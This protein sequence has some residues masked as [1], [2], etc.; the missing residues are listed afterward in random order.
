[1][2]GTTKLKFPMPHRR[3]KY[4][5]QDVQSISAPLTN[6][7]QKFLGTAEISIDA[8]SPTSPHEASRPWETHSTVSGVSGI[9]VAISE[10][11][12][13]GIGDNTETAEVRTRGRFAWDQESDIIP[14]GL[15]LSA[16]PTLE[17]TTDASSLRRRGSGST[18]VSYYDKTKLPLSISQQ[19]S[20][21]AM[22]KGL[23]NKAAE[24][25]DLESPR[26]APIP[27]SHPRRK[28]SKLD[29]TRLLSSSKLSKFVQ[30]KGGMMLGPDLLT[31]SPSILSSSPGF[32]SSDQEPKPEKKLRRV[33]TKE[34]LR[35]LQ[36]QRTEK[37]QDAWGAEHGSATLRKRATDTGNLHHLYEHYEETSI[38]ERGNSDT[39]A[40]ASPRQPS[41]HASERDTT[42]VRRNASLSGPSSP[43]VD[44]PRHQASPSFSA[45]TW[46]PFP[47]YTPSEGCSPIAENPRASVTSSNLASPACDYATSVSS[48]HTRTSRASKRTESFADFDP[49]ATSVLSLS[50]DSEDDDDQEPP[51]TA[52]SIPSVGSRDSTFSPTDY[53]RPSNTSSLQESVRSHNKSR[54]RTSLSPKPPFSSIPEHVGPSPPKINPRSSSLGSALTTTTSPRP[55]F[56]TTSSL[57]RSPSGLSQVSASTTESTPAP[58]AQP[59]VPLTGSSPRHVEVRHV[60]MLQTRAAT[61]VQPR[62]EATPEQT[63]GSPRR[64]AS[65]TAISGSTSPLSPA[66]MDVLRRSRREPT[67]EQ[68]TPI[69]TLSGTDSTGDERF[70]AV[71]KQE[72]RLLAAMRA[73]RAMMMKEGFQVTAA[74]HSD[75]ESDTVKKAASKKESLSS[76]KTVKANTLK[77]SS[78]KVPA[79]HER[80]ASKHASTIMKFPEPPSSRSRSAMSQRHEEELD[81]D[82]HEQVLMYLD[83]SMSTMNPYDMAE[84][85]PD[86]SD[87]IV[88]FD[89]S[90]FPSPPRATMSKGTQFRDSLGY[91]MTGNP[92]SPKR[93]HYRD[94]SFGRPRPDSEF[95]PTFKP[96]W[97]EPAPPL[98]SHD[99]IDSPNKGL[100]ELDYQIEQGAE[101]EEDVRERLSS[102]PFAL[103]SPTS[104][105]ENKEESQPRKK[106]IRISAVGQQLPEFGQWGDDG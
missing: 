79:P 15:G 4:P 99:F 27:P 67:T 58:A 75:S 91:S 52:T 5:N 36:S 42:T 35:S 81:A 41:T 106:A 12:A 98:P 84:P 78:T 77:P 25:L 38:R 105:Y 23:P 47:T 9:S 87:F 86:L 63:R 56:S 104:L 2:G 102:S 21:S 88:E 53:R 65:T 74:L 93:Q 8:S 17:V 26:P 20:N 39:P 7:A 31:R 72:E 28:P 59:Q 85:S 57:V 22:A 83:K 54:F 11:T 100:V 64:N 10:T 46:K 44:K 14:K 73:K 24:V 80:K 34:S 37:R 66:S 43:S 45:V 89:A 90:G 60:A 55:S 96:E 49:N 95:M 1:M 16:G 51:K 61:P 92:A 82:K 18:I 101:K 32:S 30:Q 33:L 68:G 71:T 48:R 19:T 3:P 69:L 29:L 40:V 50:S 94:S 76:I 70:I 6:K 13:A 103:D 97:P 62:H